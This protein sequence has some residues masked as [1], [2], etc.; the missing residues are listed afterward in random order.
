MKVEIKVSQKIKEF[1]EAIEFI[2][3]RCFVVGGAVRDHFMGQEA[4]DIDIMVSQIDADKVVGVMK[5]FSES[6]VKQV[7]ESHAPVWMMVID[8][9]QIEVA[10]ARSERKVS[11][12][13]SGFVFEPADEMEDM[14]RRDVSVGA[15]SWRIVSQEIFDPF[16]GIADIE[17]KVMRHVGPAF[18]DSPERIFRFWAQMVR[19][20]FD[21]D[22]DSFEMIQDMVKSAKWGM[23]NKESGEFIEGQRQDRDG[24]SFGMMIEAG[25]IPM[26]QIWRHF[27]KMASKGSGWD[28][29]RQFFI[30][31]GIS[32]M[33]PEFIGSR[34]VFAK[35]S[36]EVEWK[37]ACMI[38]FQE[39][40]VKSF[41]D[42]IGMPKAVER[43]V[44]EFCEWGINGKPEPII[45]GRHVISI[46][47]DRKVG[48]WVGEMVHKAFEAQVAG[49]FDSV[50]SG[51]EW[52]SS[53]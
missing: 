32:D 3:G 40:H 5:R 9:E 12:G 34:F 41:A 25:F 24:M 27:E 6:P 20:D 37:F 53:R 2:G 45:Q 43:R 46:W 13:K 23:F 31:S 18:K 42:N 30:K 39:R 4:I 10:Q 16:G 22:A 17:A 47:P 14:E 19:F 21:G 28:K 15:I 8:G 33:F 36:D 51:I 29:F 11:Q 48:R 52:I 26:S 38:G 35:D 44:R 49:E 1:A 50:E 7:V